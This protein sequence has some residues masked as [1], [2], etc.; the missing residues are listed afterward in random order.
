[1]PSM[2]YPGM[3]FARP[4]Q[5]YQIPDEGGYTADMAGDSTLYRWTA[6][7]T[8]YTEVGRTSNPGQSFLSERGYSGDPAL[9]RRLQEAAYAAELP[10]GGYA[11]GL[12]DDMVPEY[13]ARISYRDPTPRAMSNFMRTAAVIV[14][15]AFG[16]AGAGE[17]TSALSFTGEESPL[18]SEAGG[19][20]FSFPTSVFTSPFADAGNFNFDTGLPRGFSLPYEGIFPG[21]GSFT[22]GERGGMPR[23]ILEE[24]LRRN[25]RLPLLDVASG[26]YGL[27][28]ARR[29]ERAARP[30]DPIDLSPYNPARFDV[31]AGSRAQA[32]QDMAALQADPSRLTSTPG[33]QAGIQAIERRLASQ[34]YLGSGNMMMA[35]SNYGGEAFN[36]EMGRLREMSTTPP[37]VLQAN[38]SFTDANLR[39]QAIQAEARRA[40][41]EARATGANLRGRSLGSVGYGLYNMF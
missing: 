3:T 38:A 11:W 21:G 8:P 36:R 37:A 7:G 15:G 12:P 22:G 31:T 20:G 30:P 13:G 24:M 23:E 5:S 17:G 14:G 16:G 39:Q 35:L 10:E 34:G 29:I 2:P 6:G 41:A 28:Q 1:M 27:N 25:K 9:I 26:L 4:Q 33:Y 40:Q 32:A 19:S 18:F